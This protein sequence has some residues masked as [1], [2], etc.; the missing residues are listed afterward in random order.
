[1]FHDEIAVV[2]AEY[3]A[4]KTVTAEQPACII[5]IYFPNAIPSND[6]H[7]F[8]YSAPRNQKVLKDK[9]RQVELLSP[10]QLSRRP[11]FAD[12]LAGFLPAS[13]PLLPAAAAQV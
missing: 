12:T 13:V 2:K 7:V 6:S 1:M 4:D 8:C 3:D 5:Q 10:A 9:F 11:T